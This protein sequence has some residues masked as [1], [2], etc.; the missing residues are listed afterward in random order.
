MS[1]S[2][3][4]RGGSWKRFKLTPVFVPASGSRS[5]P[6]SRSSWNAPTRKTSRSSFSRRQNFRW[7]IKSGSSFFRPRSIGGLKPTRKTSTGSC[8]VGPSESVPRDRHPRQVCESRA[9]ANPTHLVR[10][11]AV[12]VVQHSNRHRDKEEQPVD[13]IRHGEEE[14]TRDRGYEDDHQK[15]CPH[16]AADE[17]APRIVAALSFEDFR[18][19]DERHDDRRDGRKNDPRGLEEVRHAIAD[20]EPADSRFRASRATPLTPHGPSSAADASR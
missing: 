12:V 2:P 4:R 10:V 13:H 11:Q 7:R 14:P 5:G 17:S 15:G 20:K 3:R 18:D 6:S 1:R 8:T 9:G 16:D 19:H